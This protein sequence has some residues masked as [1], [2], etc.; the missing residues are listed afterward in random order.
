MKSEQT[1]EEC[2]REELLEEIGLEIA[3]MPAFVHSSKWEPNRHMGKT[4]LLVWNG[5]VEALKF[6]DGEV[7]KVKWMGVKEMKVEINSGNFCNS[8]NTRVLDYL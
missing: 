8:L 4:Y 7:E 3:E 1:Y 6:N 2:L 5:E